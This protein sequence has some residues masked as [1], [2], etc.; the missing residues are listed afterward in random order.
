M[1]KPRGSTL[2]NNNMYHT[3]FTWNILPWCLL[4]HF[5]CLWKWLTRLGFFEYTRYSN[6]FLPVNSY[7]LLPL[8]V[9]IPL[10]TCILQIIIALNEEA[11]M[12]HIICQIE[13]LTV[14]SSDLKE[15]E[16]FSGQVSTFMVTET[17]T[18]LKND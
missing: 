18:L 2:R 8:L 1:V 11:I 17:S 6:L 4:Q 16:E 14:M 9:E 10:L 5:E 15:L 13:Y 3:F 7:L 12:W